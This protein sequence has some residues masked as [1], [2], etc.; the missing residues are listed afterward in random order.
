[1]RWATLVEQNNNKRTNRLITHDGRTQ[2]V[3]R[4]AAEYGM[5]RGTL[6]N[7]LERGMTVEQALATRVTK[8]P[9][10]NS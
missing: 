10:A 4:W 5:T 9:Y 3:A 7:R 2:S 1:M 6:R 8:G